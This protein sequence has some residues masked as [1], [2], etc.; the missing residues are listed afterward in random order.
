MTEWEAHRQAKERIVSLF[1]SSSGWEADDEV[2]TPITSP[3]DGIV[4]PYVCD[5]IGTKKVLGG[6]GIIIKRVIVEIDSLKAGA[7]TGHKSYFA[8]RKDLAR[9]REITNYF[10]EN[11]DGKRR[12]ITTLRRLYTC[13]VIGRYA[14]PDDVLKLEL[15]ILDLKDWDKDGNRLQRHM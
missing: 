7:T 15:C 14:Q 8:Y 12:G 2:P 3:I 11:L 5:V 13:D 9:A 10:Y 6:R 4:H 1:R